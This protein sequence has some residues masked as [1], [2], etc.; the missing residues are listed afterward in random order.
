MERFYIGCVYLV[1][2]RLPVPE[3]ALRKIWEIF[4]YYFV[5]YITYTFGLHVFSFF[6]ALGSQIWSFDGGADFLHISFAALQFFV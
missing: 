3:G 5:K 2:W 6:D 4:Y 1:L